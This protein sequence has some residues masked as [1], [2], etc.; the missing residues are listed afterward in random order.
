M[1]NQYNHD[2]NVS[3]RIPGIGSGG[4]GGGV[5]SATPPNMG[6]AL[7]EM[8]QHLRGISNDSSRMGGTLNRSFQ[9][10]GVKFNL[11]GILKQS[12]LFTGLVGSIFQIV[13]AMVDVLLAA[14]MPILVPAIR[15]LAGLIPWLRENVTPKI[16]GALEWLQN[17]YYGIKDML[18]EEKQEISGFLQD[19]LGIFGFSGGLPKGWAD[20]I[21]DARPDPR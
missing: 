12:Q 18:K 10:A 11:A 1:T 5:A 8:A 6:P 15:K 14:F 17:I 21:A 13:G 20:G 16:A 4:G 19:P 7:N 9:K 2:V 3:L